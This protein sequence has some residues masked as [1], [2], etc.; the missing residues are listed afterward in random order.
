V[1]RDLNDICGRL[2][3]F[4]EARDKNPLGKDAGAL[5][6]IQK[7]DHAL[8]IPSDGGVDGHFRHS[9][10]RNLRLLKSLILELNSILLAVAP[11]SD[12]MEELCELAG[13]SDCS[14]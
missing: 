10:V 1:E 7:S 14:N 11:S 13:K 5:Q 3:A 12:R 6:T 2:I 8:I 4:S 9:A